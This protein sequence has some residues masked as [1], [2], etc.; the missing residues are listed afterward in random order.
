[1]A[2]GQTNL[3]HWYRKNDKRDDKPTNQHDNESMTERGD[4]LEYGF[5]PYPHFL[6]FEFNLNFHSPA[7]KRKEKKRK[8]V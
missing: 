6:L 4:P 3:I 1:M 2:K 7:L 8:K 5:W